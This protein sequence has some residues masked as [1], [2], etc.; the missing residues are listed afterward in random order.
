LR[1]RRINENGH[2]VDWENYFA[3]EVYTDSRFGIPKNNG[4]KTLIL[5]FYIPCKKQ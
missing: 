1:G 5:D 4:Q 3:C 2:G